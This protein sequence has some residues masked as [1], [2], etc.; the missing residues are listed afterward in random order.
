[1]LPGEAS[2]SSIYLLYSPNLVEAEFCELR[3]NG[4]L[5]SSSMILPGAPTTS[6]GP[7][8]ANNL[9]VVRSGYPDGVLALGVCGGEST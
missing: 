6:K 2:R 5:G 3:H 8:L 1:M 7:G 4:V 9:S